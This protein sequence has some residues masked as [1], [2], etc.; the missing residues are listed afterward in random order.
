[1]TASAT[2]EELS[3][4]ALALYGTARA[5][6]A[7]E[8]DDPAQA[9]RFAR[10]WA[11]QLEAAGRQVRVVAAEEARQGA[12]DPDE[13]VP[14][15]AQLREAIV[16]PHRTQAPPG[17]VLLVHGSR[18]LDRERLGLWQYSVRLTDADTAI[19]VRRTLTGV[20]A[21]VDPDT[22]QRLQLDFC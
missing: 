16:R 20:D 7:V 4:E 18:L 13:Q 1:M 9:A 22:L 12:G 3:G 14:T 19:P 17:E 15:A 2:F 5:V 11:Q 8:A 6:F 10:S 21:L